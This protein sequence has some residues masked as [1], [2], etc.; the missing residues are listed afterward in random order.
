MDASAGARDATRADLPELVV[1][2]DVGSPLSLGDTEEA[3]VHP[4]GDTSPGPEAHRSGD[5]DVPDREDL[6]PSADAEAGTGSTSVP[7]PHPEPE[8]AGPEQAVEQDPQTARAVP[9]RGRDEPSAE[10]AEGET[11]ADGAASPED[12]GDAQDPGPEPLDAEP[13]PGPYDPD[14]A[15][16]VRASFD[17]ETD[18][19]LAAGTGEDDGDDPR[20][21]GSADPPVSAGPLD[22]PVSSD[23]FTPGADLFAR[24]A[25]EQALPRPQ[26]PAPPRD[27]A[28][29]QE[30][31]Q[32][33]EQEPGRDPG[34]PDGGPR[35]PEQRQE[36]DP[37][38]RTRPLIWPATPVAGIRTVEGPATDT[39]PDSRQQDRGAE[40]AEPVPGRSLFGATGR[41]TLGTTGRGTPAVTGQG[42]P[43]PSG[44]AARRLADY[45]PL[46]ADELVEQADAVDPYVQ[47]SG[48][49]PEALTDLLSS[50]EALREQIADLSLA[51]DLTGT[52][53]ARTE[54]ENL[55]AQLDDY[56][57]P[58]L[59]RMDAPL[60]AV[61]GGST[62]AGKSTL[63]N[64]LVRREISR[65]GVLRPTTRSPVLV[66]HPYDSGAFL[67]QRILPGMDRI[68][69][70]SLV[71][72]QPIE[73]DAPRV[74]ALRLV[75]HEGL[76]PGLAIVD[77]PD[78]DS[79]IEANR[80]LA[81]QL[82]GAA[83]LWLFV[84]TAAR[85][86]D[87]L[88]WETLCEAV[89]RGVTVAVVLDRVPSES[90]RRI[91]T[92][93]ATRLRERGLGSSPVFVVPEIRPVGGLLPY[94]TVAPMLSWLNRL[95]RDARSRDV[96]VRRTLAGALDSLPD[97]IYLLATAAD[98]QAAA[99]TQLGHDLETGIV[100]SRE[101]LAISL[102][103][104]TVLRG[105]VLVRWRELLGGGE[106]MNASES[107]AS[108]LR[109]L[110]R[111]PRPV[112]SEPL[113]VALRSGVCSLL[114][115]AT[116]EATDSVL[117]AWREREPG[118][119]LVGTAER[120]PSNGRL[121][122]LLAADPVG[123]EPSQAQPEDG[124]GDEITRTV[125]QW[126]D[127]VVEQAG[128]EGRKRR[129]TS[130]AASLG[131]GGAAALATLLAVARPPTG[132]QEGKVLA[133]GA[134]DAA[135][136]ARRILE[137]VLGEQSTR[138]IVS[139]A[140]R[141]LLQRAQTLIETEHIRLY[142]VLQASGVRQDEGNTLREAAQTVEE[143]R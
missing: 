103:D 17:P 134:D 73:L 140:R 86:G 87:A 51:L 40:R 11:A 27:P 63:V 72:L 25:A 89:D 48:T 143:A 135:R 62:G 141:D 133:S 24:A 113:A 74:T 71:P 137:S 98:R 94:E 53:Q 99:Y 104:S 50:A 116:Q 90:M 13:S 126:Y 80:E 12:P 75:P 5:G 1:Y 76:C 117:N 31:Q 69:E 84:T 3:A 93:L 85:Y 30:R 61:V 58:R 110:L 108:R 131:V 102:A 38:R 19:D 139:R 127:A 6:A 37:P 118:R 16:Q 132:A 57:L 26:E 47:R 107:A 121:P 105:E 111:R 125:A 136:V 20:D 65:S 66:H 44:T 46:T 45:R 112:P 124:T 70:S 52:E 123:P 9:G 15:E 18:E 36:S 128:I 119:G 7:D 35:T 83:D 115:A 21:G 92:H 34:T 54:R 91:R 142:N 39:S 68:T 43:A 77:A 56:V 55:L 64:S 29:P 95:A 109:G 33:Q 28:L 97:R 78:I 2:P 129:A 59:R 130:R 106:L 101:D 8:G 14:P 100:R 138:A 79:V 81:V 88:P 10:G 114:R 42:T 4:N 122:T 32:P 67:S 49:Q 23:L 22:E 82:L 41:G 60:L 96:V 120:R